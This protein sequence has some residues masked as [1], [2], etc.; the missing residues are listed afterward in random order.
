MDEYA[1]VAKSIAELDKKKE[2]LRQALIEFAKQ[3]D[4]DNVFGTA[5]KVSVKEEEKVVMPEDRESFIKTLKDKGLYERFSQLSYSTINSAYR[6]KELPPELAE[7]LQ[8]E[9][10]F[11]ITLSRRKEEKEE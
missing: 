7:K 10:S 8:V 1:R 4:M 2:E 3:K 11:R 5:D 6:N 9:K